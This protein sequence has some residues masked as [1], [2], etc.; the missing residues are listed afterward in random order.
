MTE[1]EQLRSPTVV[2]TTVLSNF[3]YTG[4]LDVLDG[5][6]ARL[7]TV[8]AVH[9]ELRAGVENGYDFFDPAIEAVERVAFDSDPDTA[10]RNALDR[11]EAHALSAADEHDGTL[12]TDDRAARELAAEREIS[13]TGSIGLLVQ[14]IVDGQLGIDDADRVLR[15]WIDEAGY[16]APIER[17]SD[18]LPEDYREPGGRR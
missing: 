18:A 15:R 1:S 5:V 17:I 8:A 9:D 6:P 14:L 10:L 3:A 11:G 13:V 12:A 2:D 7:V 4:D 16:R